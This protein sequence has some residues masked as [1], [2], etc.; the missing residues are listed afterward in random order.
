MRFKFKF[1]SIKWSEI[2]AKYN[3]NFSNVYFLLRYAFM[4]Y[5]NR[6]FNSNYV[7][8]RN[9]Y[10]IHQIIFQISFHQRLY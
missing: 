2:I 4:I 7:E 1:I 8:H 3:S 9:T 6:F 5:K 10:E